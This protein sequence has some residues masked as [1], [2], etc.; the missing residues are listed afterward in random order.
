MYAGINKI[1]LFS[2]LATVTERNSTGCAYC[3]AGMECDSV[4]Q[5]CVKGSYNI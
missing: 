5:T 4:R 3:P 2:F 1:N